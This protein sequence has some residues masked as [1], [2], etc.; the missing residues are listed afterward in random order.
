MRSLLPSGGS[1]AE[2]PPFS[3]EDLRDSPWDYRTCWLTELYQLVVW[4]TQ[5]AK[6]LRRFT[7]E[8]SELGQRTLL[9]LASFDSVKRRCQPPRR[10]TICNECVKRKIIASTLGRCG[11]LS[12]GSILTS[13]SDSR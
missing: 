13:T 1:L 6:D 2:P 12:G 8:W 9:R 5:R 3:V 4:V 7:F 10:L 11:A